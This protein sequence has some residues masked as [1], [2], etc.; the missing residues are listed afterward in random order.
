LSD[1]IDFDQFLL[2]VFRLLTIEQVIEEQI[3]C[4]LAIF[5]AKK[6]N[7]SGLLYRWLEKDRFGLA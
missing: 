1:K 2:Q 3:S 7:I 5:S 6:S 4:F